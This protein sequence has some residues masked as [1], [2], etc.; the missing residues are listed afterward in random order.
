MFSNFFSH[1]L[2][3]VLLLLRDFVDGKERGLQ[4]FLYYSSVKNDGNAHFN[5]LVIIIFSDILFFFFKLNFL[6]WGNTPLTK[7]WHVLCS[8]FTPPPDDAGGYNV[9]STKIVG[10]YGCACQTSKI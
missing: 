7:N 8:M 4:A 5:N 6:I 3:L 2:L 1:L 10:R 9:T